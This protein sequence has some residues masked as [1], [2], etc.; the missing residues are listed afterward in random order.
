M[1][2]SQ[3]SSE[4]AGAVGDQY[5]LA[6][7]RLAREQGI[8]DQI[9]GELDVV[10]D[11]LLG[12]GQPLAAIFLNPTIVPSRRAELIERVIRPH[13]HK[14]TAD[15]MRQLTRRGRVD[16]IGSIRASFRQIL[17]RERGEI[18]VQVVSAR[19]LTEV[20]EQQ[21][22][23]RLT[24]VLGRKALLQKTVQPALIGGLK[25]RV[26]DVVIDGTAQARLRRLRRGLGELRPAFSVQ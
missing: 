21:I 10:V 12:R 22:Q 4:Q 16:Q 18:D 11:Q 7:Y 26:G 23:Q 15:F 1:S 13:F 24:A 3:H 9:A 14:L 6:L 20:Q 5:A 25:L 8:I 19:P 2:H 17:K